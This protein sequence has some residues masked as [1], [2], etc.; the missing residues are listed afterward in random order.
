MTPIERMHADARKADILRAAL[1]LFAMKGFAA[2]TTKDLAKAAQVSEGLL[3]KHFPSKESMYQELGR[4]FT[5]ESTGVSAELARIKPSTAS[6]VLALYYLTRMVL[7]G[8]CGGESGHDFLLRMMSRSLLE[9]GLFAK[10]F[11]ESAFLPYVAPLE[12][13]FAAARKEGNLHTD[14]RSDRFAIYF[15]HHLIVGVRLHSLRPESHLEAAGDGEAHFR[16][17]V[18]FNLRGAGLKEAAIRKHLDFRKLDK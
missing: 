11:L 5:D 16:E 13:L 2:T 8:P 10:A 17:L 3:Y 6:L 18:L 14:A 15:A 7:K 12:A 9:D 1:P 4:A